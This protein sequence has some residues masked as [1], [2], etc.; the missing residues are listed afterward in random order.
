M[1]ALIT[2]TIIPKAYSFFSVEERYH[3]TIDTINNLK[4]VGFEEIYLIDNSIDVIDAE[5][6]KSNSFDK[7]NIV[8]S[9]QYNFKNKGLNEA[10]LI[11]DHIH[12]LPDNQPLFKISGR[13]SPTEQFNRAILLSDLAEKEILGVGDIK[14][15]HS[16]YFNT[17]AYLV[18]NKRT[19]EAILVSAIEE[20]IAYGRGI[21]GYKGLLRLLKT[22][23]TPQIG[24]PF[25]ISIEKA[26]ANILNVRGKYKLVEKI[27]IEGFIAGSESL[28]FIS[29]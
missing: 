4:R 28:T 29:E 10:L 27:N 15:S 11:L 9:A 14:K 21:N 19:L 7:V 1:I 18:N 17:R 5:R 20:M 12:H 25:Q 6:I 3:Q 13:Y 8:H 2:S 24:T 22:I 23:A 26:F 16:S